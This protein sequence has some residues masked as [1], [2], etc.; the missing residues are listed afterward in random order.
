LLAV[1]AA[2]GPGRGVA[3]LRTPMGVGAAAGGVG[4]G[5]SALEA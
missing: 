3:L 4:E 5:G 1:E 2:E